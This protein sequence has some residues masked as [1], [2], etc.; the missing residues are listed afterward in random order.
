MIL[1]QKRIGTW[2]I[3]RSHYHTLKTADDVR[4]YDERH[5]STPY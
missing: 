1:D 4:N 3:K 2:E 5:D